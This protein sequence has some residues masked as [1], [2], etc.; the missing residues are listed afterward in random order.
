V[1]V[2]QPSA[3]NCS[4]VPSAISQV[5]AVLVSPDTA[6][7]RAMSWPT[8]HHQLPAVR[9]VANPGPPLP[10]VFAND[11]HDVFARRRE[12]CSSRRPTAWAPPIVPDGAADVSLPAKASKGGSVVATQ[13]L[14]DVFGDGSRLHPSY[15]RRLS[16]HGAAPIP[17][18]QRLPPIR[19]GRCDPGRLVSRLFVH[20]LT[21][22]MP[23]QKQHR[24]NARSR[25]TERAELWSPWA[26]AWREWEASC[27][28]G[29]PN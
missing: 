29:T 28:C 7:S 6:G 20:V 22:G 9:V 21:Q 23:V 16:T 10:G 17:V 3:S 2:F 27:S 8:H 1:S 24:V 25:V 11:P 19:A 4:R 13:Q 26:R 18:A 12:W 14:L 5:A 15:G